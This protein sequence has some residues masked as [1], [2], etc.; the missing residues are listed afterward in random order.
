M[1]SK[2][3]G[4]GALLDES[5]WVDQMLWLFGTPKSV[6]G[7]VDHV[8]ML[9]ISSDDLV[10]LIARYEDNLTVSMHLDLFGR[11][12]EKSIVVFGDKG[13][14]SWKEASNCV[15]WTDESGEA[16]S[17]EFQEERNAMFERVAIE[18]AGVA[19][20]TVTPSCTLAD[21]VEVLKIIE[22]VRSSD[23]TGKIVEIY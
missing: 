19:S 18:F 6:F 12:H 13:S 22:A 7:I 1:S 8:S 2:E 20:G 17:K 3:L 16:Q 11:P 10:E 4:G 5:H 14:V 21:G 23:R 9:E 15:T